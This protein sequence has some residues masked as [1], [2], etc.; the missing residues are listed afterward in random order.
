[1]S[2]IQNKLM[3]P[4]GL[5]HDSRCILLIWNDCYISRSDD[6]MV[7]CSLQGVSVFHVIYTGE[8]EGVLCAVLSQELE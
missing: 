1:M 3:V 8:C 7:M 6:R 2:N 5:C 4:A